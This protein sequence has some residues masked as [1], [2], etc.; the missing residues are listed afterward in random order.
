VLHCEEAQLGKTI[1]NRKNKKLR[2]TKKKAKEW[3]RSKGR[4]A[5]K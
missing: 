5:C 4:K 3:V 2:R 1:E